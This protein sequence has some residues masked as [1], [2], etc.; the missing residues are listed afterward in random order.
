[1]LKENLKLCGLVEQAEIIPADVKKAVSTL[2]K[3]ER[4]F[5]IIFIDPPYGRGLADETL[6][7]LGKSIIADDALV[8]AEHDPKDPIKERY[9]KLFLKDRRRYGDTS[10][11][12]FIRLAE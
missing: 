8:V 7:E 9:G 4:I 11:S 2:E 5:D 12:F 6:K 10:L 1:M 3:K